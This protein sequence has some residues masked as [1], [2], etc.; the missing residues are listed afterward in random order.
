[1]R[2]IFG[3]VGLALALAVWPAV[4]AD[5]KKPDEKKTDD[6]PAMKDKKGDD[7]NG[8]KDKKEAYEKLV[9]GGEVSGKLIHWEGTQK[10]F[11]VQVTLTYSVPDVNAIKHLADLEVQYAK[12]VANR[13]LQGA[14]NTR[15]EMAK[16][17]T[18]QIKKEDQNVDFQAAADM[19]VRILH[20][21]V[22]DDKGKPRKLTA[23][24][25][26][27][28]K[29]PDKKLPGYTAEV[30]DVR[31]DSYVTVYL[32]KAKPGKPSKDDKDKAAADNKPEAIMLLVLGDAPQQK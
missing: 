13:D 7:K 16:V 31:Q 29:G 21:M 27:E 1:M 26:E 32:P 28:M 8:P 22:Y 12:C 15:N 14:V 9:I 5:E 3:C 19:K 18:V 6:K 24:E 11:T 4:A 17:Q 23:K 25:R 2:R 10:Y 20:P 30:A